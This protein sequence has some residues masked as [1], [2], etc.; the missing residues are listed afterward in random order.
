MYIISFDYHGKSFDSTPLTNDKPNVAL[1]HLCQIQCDEMENIVLSL[2]DHDELMIHTNGQTALTIERYGRKRRC[3]P[4]HPLML[5][6]HDI[7]WIGENQ[8]HRIDIKNIRHLNNAP[9]RVSRFSKNAM[10]ASAAALVMSTA[11]SCSPKHVDVEPLGGDVDIAETDQQDPNLADNNAVP[12][13]PKEED[14]DIIIPVPPEPPIAHPQP[15]GDVVSIK[16]HPDVVGI[17]APPEPIPHPEVM[18]EPP[19]PPEELEAP[20]PPPELKEPLPPPREVGKTLMHDNKDKA[21]KDSVKDKP[22]PMGKCDCSK[23]CPPPGE[24]VPTCFGSKCCDG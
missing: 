24:P 6:N 8:N 11:I 20:L 14:I 12:D 16:D 4:N 19:L 10:L 13:Q 1:S 9:S 15:M 21:D 18:G 17:P 22:R 7:L 23:P 5:F 3:A 2:N